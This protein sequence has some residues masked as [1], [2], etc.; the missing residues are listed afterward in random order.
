MPTRR[1]RACSRITYVNFRAD[2]VMDE[3]FRRR[4]LVIGDFD[5]VVKSAFAG[6]Y[7]CIL[8]N[9]SVRFCRVGSFTTE[10]KYAFDDADLLEVGLI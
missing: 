10:I 7:V 1:C 6:C 5:Y 4:T 8:F 3:T 9:Y 2:S